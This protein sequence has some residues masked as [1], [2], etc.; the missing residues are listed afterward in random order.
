MIAEGEARPG[1][2]LPLARDRQQCSESTRT[3]FEL[4]TFVAMIGAVR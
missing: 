1:D 3:P 4:F 2:R